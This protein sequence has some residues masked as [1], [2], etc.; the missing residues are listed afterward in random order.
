MG[1][2]G[3]DVQT[4]NRVSTVFLACHPFGRSARCCA[5]AQR[6]HTGTAGLGVE[7]SIG[8]DADEQIGLHPAGFLHPLLQG[9]EKVGFTGQHGAHGQDALARAHAGAVDA[10]AQAQGDLQHHIFFARA[11]LAQGA[12]VFA[13]VSGVQR[14]HHIAQ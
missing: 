14:D 9:D 8:M 13:A 4:A 6:E 12:G 3:F 11:T 1:I 5:L 2:L 7:K 10:V